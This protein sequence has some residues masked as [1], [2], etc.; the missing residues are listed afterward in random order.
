MAKYWDDDDPPTLKNLA[1]MRKCSCKECQEEADAIEDYLVRDTKL[2][3]GCD[4]PT[5]DDLKTYVDN[6]FKEFPNTDMESTAVMFKI[7]VDALVE[8]RSKV[9]AMCNLTTP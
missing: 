6:H 4:M 9:E 2:V 1:F 3:R 8:L 5:I 7:I